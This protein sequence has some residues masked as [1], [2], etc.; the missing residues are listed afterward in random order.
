MKCF[1]CHGTGLRGR[2]RCFTC[3]GIGTLTLE[4]AESRVRYWI[5]ATKFPQDVRDFEV[6]RFRK[7]IDAI[8][9]GKTEVPE[10]PF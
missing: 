7:V 8:R 5:N 3:G 6:D 10:G 2:G 1:E 4:R 9:E